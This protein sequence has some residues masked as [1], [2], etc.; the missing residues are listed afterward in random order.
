M[1]TATAKVFMNGRSQAI[2]LPKKFRVSGSEVL[3]SKKGNTITIVDKPKLTWKEFFKKY[4]PAKD[5][6]L[7]R[8]NSA[9]QKR[10]LF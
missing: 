8:D 1:T 5:F 4:G 9:P 7:V 2:R 10:D 6:V 3:I